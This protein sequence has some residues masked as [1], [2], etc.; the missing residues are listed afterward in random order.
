MKRPSE[1]KKQA[2]LFDH[3]NAITKGKDPNYWS[4][5]SES[6]RKTFNPYMI[7]R[8][9]SMNL[10]NLDIIAQFLPYTQPN[11]IKKEVAMTDDVLY[12]YFAGMI[13]KSN[14]FLKYINGAKQEKYAEWMVRLVS[15][16]YECSMKEAYDYV[17][18]M[19]DT[20]EG[21]DKIIEICEA[22]GSDPK[23]IKKLFRTYKTITD[24]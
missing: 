5:L 4:K 1:S 2:T 3:L 20:K 16:W 12:K 18:I 24:K 9:L 23:E 6:D 17:D 10:D 21:K 14:S 19:Y 11:R 8:Y 15:K 7:H 22:Y 13:P